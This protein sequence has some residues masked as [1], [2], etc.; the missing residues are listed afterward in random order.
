VDNHGAAIFI[1][2]VGKSEMEILRLGRV[3]A[4]LLPAVLAGC[5]Q[6]QNSQDLKEKTAQATAEA[7]RDAKAMAA[8]IREGWSRDKALDLNTSTKEQLLTLPGMTAAEA[9][10]II[11]GRPY[12]EPGDLVTRRMVTKVQYDK[13]SDRV[14][15]KK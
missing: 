2:A 8:G 10:R 11:A 9:D 6:P 1:Q 14:T 15:V 12:D 3:F 7:K 13:I 5:S 4:I